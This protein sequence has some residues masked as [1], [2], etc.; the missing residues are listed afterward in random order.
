MAIETDF[1]DLLVRKPQLLPRMQI[2]TRQSAYRMLVKGSVRH[3]VR[4]HFGQQRPTLTVDELARQIGHPIRLAVIRP[5]GIGDAVLTI[6]LLSAVVA[7]ESVARV[8]LVAQRPVLDLLAVDGIEAIEVSLPT[9]HADGSGWRERFEKLVAASHLSQQ[10][11]KAEG[12]KYRSQFDLVILP[13]WETD[14]GFNARSWAVGCGA[15]IAGHDPRSSLKA[16]NSERRE[17]QLLDVLVPETPGAVHEI[18]H[19]SCLMDSLGLPSDVRD[20][21]FA[22]EFFSTSA[23]TNSSSDTRVVCVHPMAASPARRWPV[24]YWAELIRR[25]RD[26]LPDLRFELLGGPSDVDL[27]DDIVRLIG[28][29]VDNLAG[30]YALGDLPQVIANSDLLLGSDSGLAHIAA[31]LGLKTVVISPHPA[32]GDPY[33]EN[34]PYRFFP[35]CRETTMVQPDHALAPCSTACVSEESH[36]IKQ[37]HPEDVVD[38]VLRKLKEHD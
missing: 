23:T 12:A 24:E 37:I 22:K 26:S 18:D 25:L 10:R 9:T 13:R 35:W 31:G 7:S 5:D 15:L 1:S 3:T 34:S 11:A 30:K 21:G 16:P 6:P 20:D 29:G 27:L 32:D 33:Q 38:V 8:A 2:G 36:C 19:L 14:T 17:F 28:P 4:G